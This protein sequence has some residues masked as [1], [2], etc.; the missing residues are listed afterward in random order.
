MVSHSHGRFGRPLILF[1][2]ALALSGPLTAAAQQVAT[3]RM[4]IPEGTVLTVRT[5]STLNSNM[6]VGQTFDGGSGSGAAQR[7]DARRALA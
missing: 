1:W 2:A 7:T 3:R 4:L 5:E 6:N